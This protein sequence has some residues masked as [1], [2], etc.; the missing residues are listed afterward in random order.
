LEAELPEQALRYFDN[1]AMSILFL[2]FFFSLHV[3]TSTIPPGMSGTMAIARAWHF[4][5]CLISPAYNEKLVWGCAIFCV[6]RTATRRHC[7]TEQVEAEVNAGSASATG[8]SRADGVAE[9]GREEA[10][11]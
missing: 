7:H 1:L 11:G 8:W 4:P 2:G 3:S 6:L 9:V 5:Q 10:P